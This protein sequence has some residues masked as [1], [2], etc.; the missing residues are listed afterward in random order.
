[1]YDARIPRRVLIES[2]CEKGAR[3]ELRERRV[4]GGCLKYSPDSEA[5]DGKSLL[6]SH[7]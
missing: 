1:M 3:G 6:I 7:P 4:G 5:R 2:G